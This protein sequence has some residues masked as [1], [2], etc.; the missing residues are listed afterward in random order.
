MSLLFTDGKEGCEDFEQLM[1]ALKKAP[2]L[3]HAAHAGGY[4]GE[5]AARSVTILC[6]LAEAPDVLL[7]PK[8]KGDPLFDSI[9]SNLRQ[10]SNELG[11]YHNSPKDLW[12]AK[13]KLDIEE[14]R[15][16]P[17]TIVGQLYFKAWALAYFVYCIYDDELS[18]HPQKPDNEK[19]SKGPWTIQRL[20]NTYQ[21]S[22]LAFTNDLLL[23]NKESLIVKFAIRHGIR[24]YGRY[25]ESK[26]NSTDP[27]SFAEFSVWGIRPN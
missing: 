17:M 5:P 9:V 22:F 3:K 19:I 7:E 25:F 13:I 2:I 6:G 8:Q 20:A 16:I 1:A 27:D 10:I 26:I 14:W 18:K 21:K 12:H 15:Q 23:D 4:R 24:V 11:R